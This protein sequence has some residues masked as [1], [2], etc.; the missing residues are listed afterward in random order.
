M[1][2]I[3][4]VILTS[5]VIG[6]TLFALR[7][8]WT[9]YKALNEVQNTCFTSNK[10]PKELLLLIPVL[11]E[12]NIIKDTLDYFG[13][14]ASK[15]IRLQVVIVG[16]HKEQ[17]DKEKHRRRLETVYDLYQNSS[18]IEEMKK[19]V[20]GFFLEETLEKLWENRAGYT[21]EAFIEEYDKQPS[22]KK[23]VEEWIENYRSKTVSSYAPR[24]YYLES[25]Q[26]KGDRA[27]QLNYGLKTYLSTINSD[28]DVIGVY[29]ADSIPDLKAFESVV[30]AICYTGADACQQPLHF[31]DTANQYSKE[32][33]N[34]ILVA[35]AI[36]Q[37][38]WSVI[39]EYP[40][41]YKYSRHK[42][43]R[44]NTYYL[45]N[46]YLNGHGQFFS[47][48]ILDKIGGFPEGVIA[49]GVQIGY[50][51]SMMNASIKTVPYFCS[52][53]MPKSTSEMVVQHSRWYGGCM[54]LY[55]AYNWSK[56]F[57]EK[58][59]FVQL[60]DGYHL[61]GAWA[62]APLVV[63]IGF[64][65]ICFVPSLELKKGLFSIYLLSLF[66]YM[67]ILPKLAVKIIGLDVKIRFVDWL[68][69]PVAIILKSIGPNVYIVQKLIS[70]VRKK[71][72]VYS[73]VER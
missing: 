72:I 40:N 30:H 16:T 39:K 4:A 64:I 38:M 23:V 73:K 3:V 43:K 26:K 59:P 5:L 60:L 70:I 52:D 63:G 11:R 22:T 6:K 33:K 10:N 8:I 54:E 32:R 34:P 71:P 68:S 47:K 15:N 14:Y 29:D 21:L 20:R 50:R 62:F 67:Y 25:P 13:K 2:E 27:T 37:T 49:D 17:S 61:Q 31:I 7:N 24:F 55:S 53:D 1:I 45:R 36:Y 57:T 58:K 19:N 44:V 9:S 35:S 51:L 12:Q 42:A 48:G 69:L 18:H 65:S 46:V 66:V 41:N 56:G 28:I